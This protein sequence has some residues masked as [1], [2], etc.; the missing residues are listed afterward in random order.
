MSGTFGLP[1]GKVTRILLIDPDG[2]RISLGKVTEWT[3]KEDIKEVESTGLDGDR[4]VLMAYN[5]CSGSFMSEMQDTGLY[6]FFQARKIEYQATGNYRYSS[7][8]GYITY[9]DNTELAIQFSD[10]ALKLDTNGEF[11][12]E[13]TVKLKVSFIAKDYSF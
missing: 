1:T 13:E 6:D 4:D 10:V 7:F 8:F 9:P 5:G 12:N 11:K 3:F 2:A